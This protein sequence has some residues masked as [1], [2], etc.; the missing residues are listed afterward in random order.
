M[1]NLLFLFVT[2]FTLT[3]CDKDNDKPK[4]PIDQ[5][6]PATQIGA[7][8]AGCLVNGEA[9][10]PNNKSV[11]PLTCDYIDGKDFRLGISKK[12]NNIYYNIGI[13]INNTQ[14]EIEKNY[15]LKA[16]GANSKFAEYVINV[17]AYPDLGY[18]STTNSVVG[19]LKITNHNFDKATLSG[20]FWFD[21][22]NSAGE[23]VQVREGRFD[24][25]Y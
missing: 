24:M 13:S 1:K 5:L 2:L 23:K 25:E 15:S 20:T 10:L 21:A 18:F 3:C 11:K 12:V 16:Y 19:E 8:T 14:L 7:N 9:F 17:N 6:P 22:V 4:T